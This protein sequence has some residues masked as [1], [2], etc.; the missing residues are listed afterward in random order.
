M[1]VRRIREARGLSID[2]LAEAA[3]IDR[4]SVIRTELARNSTSIDHLLLIAHALGVPATHLL[5]ELAS[6]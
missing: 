2:Q 1:R 5:R 4:K 3:F 6:E